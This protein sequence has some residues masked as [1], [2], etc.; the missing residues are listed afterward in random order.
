[1]SLCL[2][3]KSAGATDAAWKSILSQHRQYMYFEP[4]FC[5]DPSLQSIYLPGNPQDRVHESVLAAQAQI[6]AAF[7][8]YTRSQRVE[9][10]LAAVHLGWVN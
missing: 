10:G 6:R 1:M 2:I 4:T 8:K 3:K 5:T 7:C 9:G